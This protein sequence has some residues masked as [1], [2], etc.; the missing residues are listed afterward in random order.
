MEAEPPVVPGRRGLLPVLF[1][2]A[3][4]ISAA[5]GVKSLT[6][7]VCPTCTGLLSVILPWTG[8]ALYAG[9][10]ALAWRAPNSPWLTHVISLSVFGHACLVMEAFLLGHFCVGCLIIAGVALAAAGI[11]AHRMPGVRLSLAMS[12]LLGAGAG[13]LY[14]F[15]RVEDSLTRR[16][17]PSR[18]LD[19]APSFV[20]KKELAACGHASAVRFIVYEDEKTCNSC[21]SVGRRLIPGILEEFPQI[22]CIH[23]HTLK[24]PPAGQVL[25]VLLLLSREMRLVVV[26][27]LPA[28]EELHD[29]VRTLLSEAGAAPAGPK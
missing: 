7:G 2:V 17:W 14:P 3:A 23:R 26:E 22:V 18:I 27:G 28:S 4:A 8:I 19:R 10:A 25:P 24:D 13:L 11:A 21:S 16:F 29:L 1:A 6:G 5:V 9:L 12:L 15:D 20:D